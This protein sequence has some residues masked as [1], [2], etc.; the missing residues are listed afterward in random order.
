MCISPLVKFYILV[1]LFLIATEIGYLIEDSNIELIV[2]FS[3]IIPLIL[4]LRMRC[5][6]CGEKISDFKGFTTI[7][8]THKC[9]N[10][11]HDLLKCENDKKE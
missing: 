8:V 9:Y 4:F 3:A 11:G 5:S 7:L 1:V 2:L 10:C 6:N